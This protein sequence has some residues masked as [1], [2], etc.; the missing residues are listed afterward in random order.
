MYGSQVGINP[1]GLAVVISEFT[2]AGIILDAF[3][4]LLENDP[5]EGGEWKS[6]PEELLDMMIEPAKALHIAESLERW[7]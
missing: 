6:D 5:G 3:K 2:I 4:E 1:L 7:N